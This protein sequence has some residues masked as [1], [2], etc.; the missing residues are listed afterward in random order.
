MDVIV[1]GEYNYL[2]RGLI[3]KLNKEGH[4]VFVLSGAH[5]DR[6]KFP[7][8]YEQYDFSY[9]STSMRQIVES[10]NP[11][12]VIFMGA[13]DTSFNWSF[14][15]AEAV[16]YSTGLVNILVALSALEKD[17]RVLYLSSEEIYS[18][19][20]EGN[21]TEEMQITPQGYKAMAISQGELTC[22]NYVNSMGMDIRILRLGNLYGL[23]VGNID[24]DP[25]IGRMAREGLEQ[26]VITAN[27]NH[28]F[29]LLDV[30]DAVDY[31]YQVLD[32]EDTDHPIY[33]LSSEEEINELE[34]ASLIAKGIG[35][36]ATVEEKNIGAPYKI[37][38]SSERFRSEFRGKVFHHAS[39][40]IPKIAVAL[41]RNPQ[42]YF[43][44]GDGPASFAKRFQNAFG[45]I[46]RAVL[47]FVENMII[48]IPFFMMH[49]RAVD[50]E[51][52]SHLDLYLLYV[53]FFAII[54]GQQQAT[55]SAILATAGYLF[56]ANY[57]R[58]GLDIMLDYSTYIWIAQ[59]FILGLVVGHMKDKLKMVQDESKEEVD[60]LTGQVSD[61]S[62][63]NAVNV[64]MKSILEQQVINQND[65]FGKVY[66]IT[67]SLDQYEPEEV[68]FYAAEILRQLIRSEDVAIYTVA[69]RSFARLFAS[70]SKKARGLGNSIEY[71]KM[72]KMYEE[73]SAD[74][75][76]IN[77]DMD[78]DYPLMAD[79]ITSEEEMQLIIM[80]WGIPWD[81]MNLG[82]ANMLRIAGYLIQNAVLRAN[83]YMDALENTRYESGT[84]VLSVDAFSSLVR[85]FISAEQRDLTECCIL[86]V[87]SEKPVDE[88]K[89]ATAVGK[90]LRNSDYLGRLPDGGLYILLSNTSDENAGYVINRIKGEGYR[91]VI[92]KD[93][94]V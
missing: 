89:M 10:I 40:E 19:S 17:T 70:T 27:V 13:Y 53:L 12:A 3:D 34:L 78:P 57:N 45:N 38:L 23:P 52:F 22:A 86:R 55:F 85:A 49:N 73:I 42:K 14:H 24:L 58:S 16:K 60:Y 75:V 2:M 44:D 94:D 18:R 25:L 32:K 50:S 11:D 30:S 68:L 76:F 5:Y 35:K 4:H 8:V 21:I 9:D 48:F 83:R 81:R 31:I 62:D 71:P 72:T 43:F 90:T 7:K 46:L 80:V 64:Q 66:N 67:S 56:R 82:Q 91:A 59:L 92:T 47:P 69:N 41:R 54:Y 1:T 84:D 26:G 74:R 51:Y 63:I 79:A 39:E 77:R 88:D 87:D 29:A 33:N 6:E 15:Q 20:Y 36:N 61:I 37:V 93:I 28:S 65:S